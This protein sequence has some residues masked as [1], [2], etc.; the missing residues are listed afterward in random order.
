MVKQDTV[1]CA[2]DAVIDI[3]CIRK[4]KN[5]LEANRKNS[6]LTH[7]FGLDFLSG[8]VPLD[9]QILISRT[10]GLCARQGI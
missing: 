9:S 2:V 4:Y 7:Y 5:N 3:V 6:G 1:E 8:I 10:G